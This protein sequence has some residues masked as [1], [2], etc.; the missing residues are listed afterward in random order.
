VQLHRARERFDAE[1][2]RLVLIG[3]A[4]PKHASHF[5]KKLGL[6]PLPLL[7]DEER[8]SYRAARLERGSKA[9]LLGPRSVLS[10]IKHSA[11]SGVIQGRPIGDVAQMGGEMVVLTDGTIAWSHAQAHAGDTISPDDLLKAVR[12]VVP[13]AG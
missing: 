7:A 13:S 4:T 3:Q 2:V 6:D 10:G 5:R 8:R 1:G 9:Q 11:R 12:S